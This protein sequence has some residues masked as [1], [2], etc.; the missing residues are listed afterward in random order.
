MRCRAA[1]V[2]RLDGV[3]INGVTPG[4]FG[5]GGGG[6]RGGAGGGGASDVQWTPDGKSLLV[7]IVKPNRG[8]PPAEEPLVPAGPHVQESLGGA[9]GSATLED[10]LQNPH[11]EELFEYYATSQLALVDPV[12]GKMTLVGKPGIFESV[13]ISPNGQNFLVTTVQRPF[14]YLL[15]YRS[16]P[17][18]IEVWDHAGKM[19]HKVASQPMEER[20]S[21]TGVAPGPRNIGWRP[22][23]R[24]P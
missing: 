18:E 24:P 23:N 6:G 5:G 10:M 14:S 3:H 2:H 13:R 17:K 15:S 20:V 22:T 9:S 16:F 21:L 8:A 1:R 11:D 4:G 7:E 12:T 19:V